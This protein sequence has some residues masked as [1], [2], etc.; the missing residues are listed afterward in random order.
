[1]FISLIAGLVTGYIVSIPPLGP[2]SFA[3]ISKGFKSEIRGG[4]SIATGAAFMDFVYCMIAFGGVSLI[5]SLLPSAAGQFYRENIHTIQ[6]F[7]TYAGCVIVIIYGV[8][9]M[10][11]KITFT[12]LEI[13]QS[14]RIQ[15]VQEKAIAV[16]EKAKEFAVH[17]HVPVV[18]KSNLGGLFLMGVLLCL[19]S[20]T[21]PASWIAFVSYL[22]GYRLI[23]NSFLSG[24]LFSAGAFLGTLFWF[25]TLLKLITGNR[26]RINPGTVNKLNISAGVILILLGIFLFAKA[27][28]SLI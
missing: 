4:L 1:M 18:D 24:I 12:D 5:I 27:S 15:H 6:V 8:K 19:S 13:R 22:K 3:L 20:V 28:L 11:T 14:Q 9:I 23:D 21:L 7:L 2:I 25:Y 10:K 26:H 16:G 17:H